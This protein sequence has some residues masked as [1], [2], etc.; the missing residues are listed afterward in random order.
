MLANELGMMG[1]F[2]TSAMTGF[3]VDLV[4]MELT[5]LIVNGEIPDQ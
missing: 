1:F 4:F 2:E 5:K 3:N